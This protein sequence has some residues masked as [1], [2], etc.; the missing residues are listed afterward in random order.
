MHNGTLDALLLDAVRS[1]APPK[2]KAGTPVP[3]PRAWTVSGNVD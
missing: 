2:V 1:D 3:G